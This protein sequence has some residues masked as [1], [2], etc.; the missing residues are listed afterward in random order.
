MDAVVGS[1]KDYVQVKENSDG[2]RQYSG[3]LNE[4]QIPAIANAI[5]AFLFKSEF[6]NR[7]GNNDQEL[8]RIEKDIFIKSVTGEAKENK[9]GILES[10]TASIAVQGI[11][12]YGETQELAVDAVMKLSDINNTII[13][14]PDLTGKEVQKY[15]ENKFGGIDTKY[16]GNYKNDII[17]EKDGK[18]VKIGERNLI[19]AHV[20]DNSIA[21]RYYEVV[22]PGYESYLSTKN[23]FTFDFNPN[24]NSSMFTYKNSSGQTETGHINVAG[25]SKL[26]F[27]LNV[28]YGAKPVIYD[29]MF[30]RVFE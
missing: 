13:V 18:F 29:N 10:V 7:T 2:S 21:G 17:I 4:T 9:D 1:L 15:T 20:E 19:I 3:S 24:G 27:D 5:S 14:K 22:N 26:Y 6:R 23:D 11:D 28:Q 12:K 8:N 16:V 25:T 30:T